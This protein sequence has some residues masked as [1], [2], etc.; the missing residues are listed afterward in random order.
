MPGVIRN[1]KTLLGLF[2]MMYLLS[3]C[4]GDS[5]DNWPKQKGQVLDE[6]TNKPIADAIVV[7]RWKGTGGYSK[8]VCFHVESTIADKDGKFTIPAWKN[9]TKW[10]QTENQ[11]KTL[12][13][14]K[15]GYQESRKTYKERT[16]KKGKYYQ[17]PFEGSNYEWLEYLKKISGGAGCGSAGDSEKN[18][19]LL[20]EAITNDA[21]KIASKKEDRNI[22][23][24][25]LYGLESLRFG[26]D[27]ADQNYARRSRA[28]K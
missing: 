2:F 22:V 14:Y 12:T 7:A 1:I 10:K 6:T 16:D 24:I 15:A 20:K 13:V 26:N 18:L 21:T 5:V 28:I 4:A 27:I 9:D 3:A 19:I 23:N 17:L 25:L 8:T 11:H